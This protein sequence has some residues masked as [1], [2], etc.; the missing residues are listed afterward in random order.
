M[1]PI[2]ASDGQTP[3]ASKRVIGKHVSVTPDDTGKVSVGGVLVEMNAHEVVVRCS[4][5]W[6]GKKVNTN[7]HFPRLGF[8]VEPTNAS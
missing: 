8:I 1:K 4:G 2:P 7:V 5:E 3:D 6:E